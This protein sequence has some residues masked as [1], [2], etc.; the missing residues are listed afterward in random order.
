MLDLQKCEIVR[1]ILY[2]SLEKNHTTKRH[3]VGESINYI[4]QMLLMLHM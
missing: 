2:N 3:F 4:A 1:Y